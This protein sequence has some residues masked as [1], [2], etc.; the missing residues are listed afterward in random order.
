MG[1]SFGWV[2]EYAAR[3]HH[4]RITFTNPEGRGLEFAD[5]FD[6]CWLIPNDVVSTL[7]VPDDDASRAGLIGKFEEIER[8]RRD[9]LHI[10][11]H[12]LASKNYGVIRNRSGSWSIQSE[13]GLESSISVGAYL[14]AI[15]RDGADVL[16]CVDSIFKNSIERHPPSRLRATR[17]L[18]TP[19][20][21]PNER[22][23]LDKTIHLGGRSIAG[24][25]KMMNLCRSAE[26]I[27]DEPNARDAE[28]FMRRIESGNLGGRIEKALMRVG[29]RLPDVE[30]S[31]ELM[32]NAISLPFDDKLDDM[33]IKP[34]SR[35]LARRLGKDDP[36]I[37]GD[38][39]ADE[40]ER[41]NRLRT[42]TLRA[43][44]RAAVERNWSVEKTRTGLFTGTTLW[45]LGANHRETTV[46]VG[47]GLTN[48]LKTKSPDQVLQELGDT[49]PGRELM[50]DAIRLLDSHGPIETAP[51]CRLAP[52]ASEGPPLASLEDASAVSAM[53]AWAD[54]VIA[55][56][57][58]SEDALQR[59][60]D[61]SYYDRR[62]DTWI[63][64]ADWRA[65]ASQTDRD[66][67]R[68]WTALWVRVDAGDQAAV[69][70]AKGLVSNA[71]LYHESPFEEIAFAWRYRNEF[72]EMGRANFC[73]AAFNEVPFAEERAEL[74]DP[75]AQHHRQDEENSALDIDAQS[76]PAGTSG[77]TV[78]EQLAS[79]LER[80]WNLAM[81][82][83]PL[84][85]AL[86]HGWAEVVEALD[87]NP[88]LVEVL[89]TRADRGSDGFDHPGMLLAQSLVLR[90]SLLKPTPRLARLLL[91][92]TTIDL[93]GEAKEA[94]REASRRNKKIKPSDLEM[95]ISAMDIWWKQMELPI[96]IAWTRCRPGL[97]ETGDAPPFAR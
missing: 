12:Y 18:N 40:F 82:D 11:R 16:A 41:L 88:Y 70:E 62:S 89:L 49:D 81:L 68:W 3:T 8:V 29:E 13:G 93:I 91:T 66:S 96:A 78:R 52:T 38:Q 25:V 67:W 59:Y 74:G 92:S 14:T 46:D 65:I 72:P 53:D 61:A 17:Y 60:R 10:V 73:A 39:I 15:A 90:W 87:R 35:E 1:D 19:G 24:I 37:V 20:D 4:R 86:R 57:K 85:I 26:A 54:V 21:P 32:E 7:P 77:S 5:G 97:S 69:A 83:H 79:W 23:F 42:V 64:D 58:K 55:N 71:E 28:K 76:L 48:A 27:P 47:V 2:D 84:G 51:R 31:F 75:I 33:A 80:E 6:V 9:A 63:S 94:E 43:I 34:R 22:G 30:A 36:T 45:C 44:D 50:R 95:A 56:F